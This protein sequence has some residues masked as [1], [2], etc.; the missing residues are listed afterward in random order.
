MPDEYS[1]R[2]G[3]RN[4][5]GDNFDWDAF[6]RET[7]ELSAMNENNVPARRRRSNGTAGARKRRHIQP[8]AP[9]TA[10]NPVMGEDPNLSRRRSP[11]NAAPNIK[12]RKQKKRAKKK[13]K[14]I[15]RRILIGFF[16]FILIMLVVCSGM[17]VGMY[18]AVS[19]EIKEMNIQTL[20]LNNN[21][22]IYYF[23]SNGNEKEYEQLQSDS[24]RI[25]V[26]SNRISPSFK[27]AIVSI[28]DERFYKHHGVDI[29]R[30]L[31]AT[32]GYIGS[33]IGIGSSN[34]GGST[35]T[36]Q[37][38]KN[39]TQ[40]DD[41]KPTRKV[42]EMMRA[43]ALEKELSKDEILT[44]YC[45]IVY[46][47]NNCNGVEAAAQLYFG[48]SASELNLQES[49]SIAGIT[50]YPSEYDPIA[51]PEKNIEK[52]NTVLKKMYELGK[53]T[54]DEYERAVGTP[55]ELAATHKGGDSETTSYF[56]DAVVD[57]VINDLMKEKSY[58]RDF[59]TRQ[60]YNGGFK[61][62]ATVD[63]YVQ[64]VMEEVFEDTSNFPGGGK[65]QSAMIVSDPYTGQ[66]KGIIG[67]LGKKTDVRGWNRATQAMRQPGSSIKPLSVY[68]P[69]ID[70]GKITET[71]I[72]KDEQITIDNWTPKNSYSGYKGEMTVRDAIARSSNIP[73]VKIMH[74]K[75]GMSNSYGY[76]KNKFHISTIQEKDQNYPSLALGGL[77]QGVT[78]KEMA[79]A[80][81]V[82]VNSGKYITPYTYSKVTDGAGNTILENH[83][84]ESQAISESAAY[85][86]ADLL[87]GP[88]NLPIG[89]ATEAKL[90]SGMPTY[91]KTGTTDD[92]FDKWFV[93]FTPYYVG[94]CW[95]GFDTPSNL[96]KAGITGNPCLSAWKKVFD[97][98]SENQSYKTISKPSS[99]VETNVCSISGM[100][101]R[102]GCKS[103]K[104]YFIE[105]T[106]PKVTC[107]NH[108]LDF[109][110]ESTPNPEE[111]SESPSAS[112]SPDGNAEISTQAPAQ[113]SV[114]NTGGTSGTGNTG[115]STGSG[116]TGSTDS[117]AG[118]GAVSSG[119]GSGTG[120][121]V[122][123]DGVQSGGMIDTE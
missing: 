19:R 24:N 112:P 41:F 111:A 14:K 100:K 12:N 59:A 71:D 88:V 42:K 93:G 72:I 102:A 120:S 2:R 85:I 95:F 22:I 53:I 34:Y 56:A 1:R 10:Y 110:A 98:L 84:N 64:G 81:G 61:I 60:V 8:A 77:T 7:A 66:I 57:E 54:K 44:M 70:M 25:W 49:A 30:T 13:N 113:N 26:D 106:Q 79:A 3:N 90:N 58:T 35:I 39:I 45:N 40:E 101:P 27:D 43:I 96:A 68:G 116:T 105:G 80:Y 16:A 5:S 21:S 86:T 15:R 67:G 29:K 75:V 23:D 4:Y 32:F 55:L 122:P 6:D 104:G 62:Y 76:L 118:G 119:T 83:R 51:H 36:Q 109:E 38:I 31:G 33:K 63:P 9:G 69:G 94:A 82:F 74:E 17:F 87:S 28:E 37:V 92:N 121:I 114:G 107:N 78:V 99:V 65:A 73:A 103:V 48:K 20:A 89:T 52:R 115:G 117:G 11:A 91:G 97:K 50:Q 123:G 18:A 46:F 47:A 108:F